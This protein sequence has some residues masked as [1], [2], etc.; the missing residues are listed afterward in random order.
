MAPIGGPT[1]GG[2]AGFGSGGS[3][4]GPAEAL[5]VIGDH[6]YAYSGMF[7]GSNTSQQ[8]FNFTTGNYYFVGDVQVNMAYE[9]DASGT[10]SALATQLRIS[11]NDNNIA[12]LI[13][14]LIGSDSQVS[15]SQPIIIPPYTEVVVDIVGDAN[16]AARLMG[17]S[18]TGR[19]YRD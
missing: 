4:T 13:A 1:G 10:P 14:G 3:F 11:L 5:E 8:A 19:I 16:E 15:V 7:P 17:A 9:Y 12:Q 6:A 18:M 2:Q